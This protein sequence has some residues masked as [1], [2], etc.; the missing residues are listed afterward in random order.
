MQGLA[1]WR[2]VCTGVGLWA[3]VEEG[4]CEQG[5]WEEDEL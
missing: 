5:L 4:V 2:A 3:D 1:L